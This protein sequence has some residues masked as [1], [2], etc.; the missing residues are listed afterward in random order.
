MHSKYLAIMT[1][2]LL[3]SFLLTSST[4]F[5]QA[6]PHHAVSSSIDPAPRTIVGL[7]PRQIITQ[8]KNWIAQYNR[9]HHAQFDSVTG[10][11]PSAASIAR[12]NTYIAQL[13]QE[14]Q[15]PQFQQ[16]LTHQW[17]ARKGSCQ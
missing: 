10:T 6:N 8:E 4:V 12:Q 14:S 7:T 1:T 16:Q 11:A 3:G 2:T 5:A 17:K 13:K 15:T 9:L